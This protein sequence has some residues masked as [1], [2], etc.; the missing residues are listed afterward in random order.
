MDGREALKEGTRLKLST[1]TGYTAFTINKEVGRGGS[2]IVYDA[3]YSDNRDNQKLVRI[4]ECYPYSLHLKREANGF[5]CVPEGEEEAFHRAKERMERAYQRNEELFGK[6]SLTN[7]VSHTSDIYEAYGTVYIVSVYLHGRTLA[8]YQGDSLQDLVSLFIA[9][10]KVLKGIHEAGFLYLDVKPENILTIEGSFDLVQLF[11][12][13][14]MVPISGSAGEERYRPSYTRGYAP[15]ELQ[16][17]RREDLGRYTDLYSLGAVF[18]YMLWHKT[19]TA[20]DG[21]PDAVYDFENSAYGKGRYQDRVYRLITEFFHKTLASYPGDR[22]QDAGE[23]IRALEEMDRL[24]DAHRPYLRSSLIS[25][26]PAFYGRE[27]ELSLL[28]SFLWEKDYPTV[29]LYGM[30]GMGKSS[31]VREYLSRY[32]DDWDAV[33]WLYDQEKLFD[34]IADDGQVQLS[35]ISRIQEESKK[36]Y[37]E[38]KKKALSLLASEQRILFIIDNFSPYHLEEV[39][40]F[41]SLGVHVLLVSREALPEGMYPSLYLREM[42][43]ENLSRL[44]SYFGHCDV[45]EEENRSCFL[46]IA[47]AVSSHTLLTELI[48][49]Q[50]ARSFLSLSVAAQMVEEI[51]PSLMPGEEIDYVRDLSAY[52]GSIVKILDRLVQIDHFTRE[53]RGIL[54]LLSLFDAPGVGEELFCSLAGIEGE[55]EKKGRKEEKERGEGKELLRSLEAAGWLKKEGEALFLHPLMQDYVRSWDWEPYEKERANQM[56]DRLYERIL[57]KGEREDS[58]KQFPLDYRPLYELLKVAKQMLDHLGFASAS[59][60]NLSYRYLMDAPMDQEDEVSKGMFSL[61]RQ[62]RYLSPEKVLQLYNTVARMM[63]GL[64]EPEDGLKVLKE[65]RRYLFLHPRAYYASVYHQCM[66]VIL[67]NAN[68]FGNLK[69]VLREE[70]Y[71]IWYAK[72]SR[73]PEAKKQL[74]GCLLDKARTIISAGLERKEARELLEE[75]RVI[76]EEHASLMDYE[77]YQYHC[78]AAT[79]E[80]LDGNLEEAEKH[81]QATN[82]IA[83]AAPDSDKSIVDHLMEEICPIRW[84]IGQHDLAVEALYEAIRL[85]EKHEESFRYREARFNAYLY[86]GRCWADAGKF[87]KAEEAF[88]VAERYLED[89]PYVWELPLCPKQYREKAQEERRAAAL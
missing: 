13:D 71:A 59:S 16:K 8:Q 75:A 31:L 77:N 63:Q 36:E 88:G 12:F 70:G 5:L 9:T 48:A 15:L 24:S 73:K 74:A 35:T 52:H 11:D 29:S 32:S 47:K 6:A 18:F 66:A 83:Y 39:K 67:H 42:E 85:C 45:D 64:Y 7:V 10:A 27:G 2:C 80:G 26:L 28:H 37:I 23:A 25:P 65:M 1:Q 38:R 50:V 57:P 56:M 20:L 43:E 30:G 3:S 53:D 61:I 68:E 21:E 33:L 17:G 34:V 14:S 58:G 4:K 40:A 81:L 82:E 69:K 72:L 51:G 46:R 79:L 60:E 22:Y 87:V 19:P 84:I 54:K 49:R 86:M 41:S 78:N 76:L 89:S 62:Q 44:F 55:A